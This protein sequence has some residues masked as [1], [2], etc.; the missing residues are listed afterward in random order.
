MKANGVGDN[1]SGLAELTLS[2]GAPN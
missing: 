1:A 2:V